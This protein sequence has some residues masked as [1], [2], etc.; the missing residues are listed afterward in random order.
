MPDKLPEDVVIELPSER[1]KTD[2]LGLVLVDLQITDE[3]FDSRK[4]G[5]DDYS[6]PV[7]AAMKARKM[8]DS[9]L[10]PD[11]PVVPGPQL[12]PGPQPAPGSTLN[13]TDGTV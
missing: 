7:K 8:I 11:P 3:S 1:N 4:F 5:F 12:A 2:T 13:T 6:L 9:H 10:G